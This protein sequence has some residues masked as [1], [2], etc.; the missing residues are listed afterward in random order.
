MSL[1]T[2]T[3]RIGF[4]S[5]SPYTASP[6]WSDISND[7]RKITIRRGRFHE[8]DRIEAGTATIELKNNHGDY[9]PNKT[10]GAYYPNIL[11]V[12]RVN[13]RATY[14]GTTYDLYTG[15]T[16]AWTPSWRDG[17]GKGPLMGVDCVDLTKALSRFLLPSVG[18]SSELS[19][20]RVGHVLNDA[21][22]NATERVIDAGQTLL[23]ATGTLTNTYAMAHLFDVQDTE[24]GL[25][26]QRGDGYV[27]FQ[28]RLKRTLTSY[29]TPA[30][31]FS[32]VPGNKS[33]FGVEWYFDDQYLYNDIAVTAISGVTQEVTDSTSI[34]A[35]GQRSLSKT[36][37][38]MVSDDDA[39]GEA[40]T[41]LF[42]YKDPYLRAKSI[43]IRPLKNPAALWPLVLD[44]DISD[45]VT[46]VLTQA[47]ISA[48]Y[49]IEAV[50]HTIDIV[51]G[52][53]ESQFELKAMTNSVST[54]FWV[55]GVSALGASTAVGW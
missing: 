42:L 14:S 51:E 9:W 40:G 37:M 19:G 53:W 7:V 46:V 2:I 25:V 15:F 47:S 26:F 24:L 38:L 35:Y 54:N 12:K 52:T 17:G 4:A 18:Y 23:Q 10:T 5:A 1:P 36:N 32:D 44:L 43:T 45:M 33:Y 55:V 41:L 3:A 20:A 34:T 13:I 27:I 48:N 11:P 39:L 21:G 29:I 8:M 22:W 30:G 28:D 31:I 49:F 50:T 16:E 6:T